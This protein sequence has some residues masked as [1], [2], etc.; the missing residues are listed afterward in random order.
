MNSIWSICQQRVTVLL[1]LT[2]SASSKDNAGFVLL[3]GF[4]R[5]MALMLVAKPIHL[6]EVSF[7]SKCMLHCSPDGEHLME[8]SSQW[9]ALQHSTET[10]NFRMHAFCNGRTLPAAGAAAIKVTF[11]PAVM[12]AHGCLTED[13]C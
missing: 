1:E 9:Q 11:E 8:G 7:D 5:A 6:L 4:Q 2:S 10:L 3:D 13:L 12:F